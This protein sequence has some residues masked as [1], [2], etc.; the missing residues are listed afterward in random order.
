M[1]ISKIKSYAKLNLTLNITGRK[2]ALHKIESLIGFIDLHDVISINEHHG[3]KH[4]I[5]FYG[6]FSKNIDNLLHSCLDEN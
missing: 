1:K 3:N 4:Q 2:N 6:K 5:S